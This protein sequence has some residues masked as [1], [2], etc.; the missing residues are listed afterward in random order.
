MEEGPTGARM[1]RAPEGYNVALVDTLH[2]FTQS[3]NM[4]WETVCTV[5]KSMGFRSR[6]AWISILF[7]P[8]ISTSAK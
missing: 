8:L 1:P 5:V 6:E 7:V 3:I 4:C 2:S